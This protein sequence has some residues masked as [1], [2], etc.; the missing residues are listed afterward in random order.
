VPFY[1]EQDG[2]IAIVYSIPETTDEVVSDKR[3]RVPCNSFAQAPLGIDA[4]SLF[5][6]SDGRPN[7]GRIRMHRFW[8][9]PLQ[10][11]SGHML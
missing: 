7:E 11:A 1:F 9:H 8:W 4:D 6:H 2:A 3:K 5:R 10:S